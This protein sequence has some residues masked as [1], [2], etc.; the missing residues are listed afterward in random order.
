MRPFCFAVRFLGCRANEVEADGL[1]SALLAAGGREAA[2]GEMPEI[3][4]LNTCAVTASAQAQSRNSVRRARRASGE[5][6]WV[7][8]TGCAAQLDPHGLAALGGVDLVVG[9]RHKAGLVTVLGQLGDRGDLRATA[10]PQR[11]A[12]LA[13]ALAR[14]GWAPV[15][16]HG[17]ATGCAAQPAA[18][19]AGTPICWTSDPT[20]ETLCGRPGPIP[21]SRTRPSIKIQDGCSF[22]CTYCV[23]AGLRGRPV[24]RAAADVVAEARRLAAA[25]CRE[26]TLTGINLGLYGARATCAGTAGAHAPAG[27]AL[28]DALADLLSDLSRVEGLER[29]RLSSLEPMTITDRLL[30]RIA[31]LPKIARSFHV[32]FQSGDDDVLGRMGR[33]YRAA[34]LEALAGRIAARFPV[35]G[36]G[37]DVVAGFP[38]E[39]PEAFARTLALL[40]RLPVTYLH[41]FA[42]SERPGTP[43]AQMTPRIP[44]AERKQ[45]V[46]R[47]RELDARLRV[48]FQQR[49]AGRR[50]WLVVERARSGWFTG[51]SGEYVRMTGRSRGST[52]GDWVTV[53]AG[54]SLEPGRQQC[55][56]A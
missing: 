56:L 25:G 11:A 42:Y 23:V 30:D 48:R 36:L 4:V 7:I 38:G 47:L 39:S 53:V 6:G 15:F 10:G 18:D 22:H 33:P 3:T 51:M 17:R 9:N 52:P 45:R 12:V 5:S 40:E 16:G 54:R 32:P 26:V 20:L 43:A 8:V 31:A 34:D 19:G 55:R 2:P 28:E 49:L 35:C 27:A 50:C 14:V 37:V 29:I 1:R 21:R 46:A 13:G 44:P 41:A 24:S